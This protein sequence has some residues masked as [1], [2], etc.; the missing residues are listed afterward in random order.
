V[1]EGAE[2]DIRTWTERNTEIYSWL[3]TA[4]PPPP[5]QPTPPLPPSRARSVPP[6]DRALVRMASAVHR[7]PAIGWTGTSVS[8]RFYL[9]IVAFIFNL[10]IL[11]YLL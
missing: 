5:I 6:E 8:A 4:P 9:F 10:F 2:A 7:V 1:C 3:N 11:F